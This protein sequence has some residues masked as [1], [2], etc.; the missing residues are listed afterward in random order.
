MAPS[1]PEVVAAGSPHPAPPNASPAVLARIIYGILGVLFPDLAF[2]TKQAAIRSN[3]SA[4]ATE[5][6]RASQELL[7]YM[8]SLV[9]QRSAELKEDLIN[10]LITTQPRRHSNLS[11]A[12]VVQMVFLMLVACN[13]TMVNMINLVAIPLHHPW[14]PPMRD[15]GVVELPVHMK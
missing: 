7:D 11:K 13:A 3:G 6:S 14:T 10:H 4:T 1:A 15:V 5:A 2:L 9:D 8:G 12:N